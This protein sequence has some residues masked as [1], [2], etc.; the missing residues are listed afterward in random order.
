MNSLLWLS[1]FFFFFGN[2]GLLVPFPGARGFS[3]C[4]LR[5]AVVFDELKKFCR[6]SL[7]RVLSPCHDESSNGKVN[8]IFL[9]F[10][11]FDRKILYK[12]INYKERRTRYPPRLVLPTLN[13][14]TTPPNTALSKKK[15]DTWFLFVI[16]IS[17]PD[18]NMKDE[19]FMFGPKF[20]MQ[21]FVVSYP[22]K[23]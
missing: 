21:V 7:C 6:R 4:R 9:F 15:H 8:A 3:V 17:L 19:N 14:L 12:L 23:A 11:L 2:F 18:N 5:F 13:P 22:K 10:F 1:D 20:L 16:W